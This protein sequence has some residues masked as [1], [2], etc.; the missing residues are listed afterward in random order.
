MRVSNILRE[1]QERLT[2]DHR[3]TLVKS[4]LGNST[5]PLESLM[6]V[7]FPCLSWQVANEYRALVDLIGFNILAMRWI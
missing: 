4:N 7:T 6:K 2:I 5:V 1:R 3:V